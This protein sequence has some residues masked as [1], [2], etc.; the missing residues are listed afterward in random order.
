MPYTPGLSERSCCT[1]RRVAWA[2]QIPM[3]RAMEE[4]FSCLPGIIDKKVV[5]AAC[6][7]KSRCKECYFSN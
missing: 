7:D 1:L 5:C 6:K 4:I 2:M 3:T